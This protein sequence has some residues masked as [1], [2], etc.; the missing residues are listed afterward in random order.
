LEVIVQLRV[1][2]VTLSEC[3]LQP[4]HGRIAVVLADT[5]WHVVRLRAVTCSIH[6]WLNNPIIQPH[7]TR[8]D[9]PRLTAPICLPLCASRHVAGQGTSPLT[10]RRSGI[11]GIGS[12]MTDRGVDATAV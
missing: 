10:I 7:T 2:D 9:K 5:W 3:F 8:D 1:R 4:P 6:V 12:S 11:E